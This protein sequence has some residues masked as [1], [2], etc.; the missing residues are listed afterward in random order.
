MRRV[1]QRLRD[2]RRHCAA[3]PGTS[4]EI[5][6]YVR[7]VIVVLLVSLAVPAHAEVALPD[8]LR[9]QDVATLARSR[10][11]EI[12]AAKARARAAAQRPASVSRLDDPTVA[13][14]LDHVP[15]NMMGV[16]GSVTIEQTFPLS[17]VRGNRKRVAE[18]A[19][20]RELASADRVALDVELDALEAFWMLA[21][22]RDA[23]GIVN[24]QQALA[25]QLEAAALARYSANTGAQSDVLRAQ[26]ETARLTAEQRAFAA[27]IRGAEVMLNTALARDPGAAIPALDVTV[28]EREPPASDAVARASQRRPELRAGRAEIEEAEAE[29]R[30]MRSM[31]SPMAM[32][33][34][35]PAYTMAEGAGWMVMVGITIPLWRGKL[36]ASV[37]EADAM[38]DM[39]TADLDAMRRM[40]DGEARSARES[41]IAARERYR[42][43][44]DDVV[45]R[46]EQAVAPTLASYSAGQVPLVSVVEAA[47]ALWVAQR[48]LV[49]AR[50][51]LGMAWA[52]LRRAASEEVTP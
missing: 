51:Q 49:A 15:F 37:A 52:R 20:R 5:Y 29:V 50:T 4:L 1:L 8:P 28:P 7:L 10:R 19:L 39:A 33:R 48:D 31:Y 44:R 17:R 24:R 9:A 27:E 38:V 41:V 12:V 18:A 6:E 2:P 42:A 13:V 34:T 23:A 21:Q 46:A 22:L 25:K 16:D 30:V 47:Q 26:T 36:R 35:G 45:P 11:S 3:S 14:S 40:A 43:L 32:V